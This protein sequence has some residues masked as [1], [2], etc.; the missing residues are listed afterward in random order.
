MNAG[1]V[2]VASSA[3]GWRPAVNA[4]VAASAAHMEIGRWVVAATLPMVP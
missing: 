1:W 4:Y 3:L 2:E